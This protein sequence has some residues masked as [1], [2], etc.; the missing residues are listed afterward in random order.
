MSFLPNL[1]HSSKNHS[2][3]SLRNQIDKVFENFFTDWPE[4]NPYDERST[5]F[6][7]PAVDVAETNEHFEIKAELPD[8]KKEDIHLEMHGNTLVLHGEKKF[9]KEEKK[10]KGY[11]LIERTYGSFRRVI[12]LPFEIANEES[13]HAT[14]KDGLLTVMIA[15]PKESIEKQRKI[16]IK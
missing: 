15:K 2:P 16:D 14:Y 9:E 8:M 10:D 5:N 4:V 1:F 13:I 3:S 7:K 12:P 6:L 11:H